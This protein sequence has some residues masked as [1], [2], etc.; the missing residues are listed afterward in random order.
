MTRYT[1]TAVG[2]V[3]VDDEPILGVDVS[4]FPANFNALQFQTDS[5]TGH[6][7]FNDGIT[8]NVPITTTDG[9]EEYLGVD[10]ETLLARRTVKK[11]KD[12]EE[13]E[14]MKAEALAHS[15]E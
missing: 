1:I 8:P 9:I 3:R 15:Q 6:I 14:R 10:L 13:T 11:T 2:N 12:D 4:E 5:N 7:E